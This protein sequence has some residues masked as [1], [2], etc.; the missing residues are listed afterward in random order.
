MT[1]MPSR[2][3]SAGVSA[4][5]VKPI[6]R[7]SAFLNIGSDLEPSGLGLDVV[8]IPA[9][10]LGYGV[11]PSSLA[12][13]LEGGS[14]YSAESPTIRETERLMGAEALTSALAWTVT[15]AAAR[16]LGRDDLDPAPGRLNRYAHTWE[17]LSP[18]I[19]AQILGATAAPLFVIE[20]SPP[21]FQTATD[22]ATVGLAT[23]SYASGHANAATLV[24]AATAI[25]VIHAAPIA[26]RAFGQ[27]LSD[28]IERLPGSNRRDT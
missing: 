17:D 18:L 24:V 20:N 12:A 1:L 2:T 10:R 23:V 7:T 25:F 26:G 14:G 4:S 15:A 3:A 9:S 11:E 28:V 21:V 27:Y 19:E 5:D 22:T 6:Y 13:A 8:S 16:A